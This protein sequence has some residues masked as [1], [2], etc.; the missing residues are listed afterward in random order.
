MCKRLAASNS[1]LTDKV[2]C[3]R[4]ALAAELHI[5]LIRNTLSAPLRAA[6]GQDCNMWRWSLVVCL[7]D[8]W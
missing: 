5:R 1:L 3:L 8:R 2:D 7:P 4:G 6:P